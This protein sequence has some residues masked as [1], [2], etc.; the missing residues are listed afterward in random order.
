M[1]PNTERSTELQVKLKSRCILIGYKSQ[2][3]KILQN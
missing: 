1:K 2:K 3:K